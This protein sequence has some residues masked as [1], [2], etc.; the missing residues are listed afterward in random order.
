[1]PKYIKVRVKGAR[2]GVRAGFLQGSPAFLLLA[3]IK[4]NSQQRQ[5]ISTVDSEPLAL[6]IIIP[7]RIE[8][9]H[10]VASVYVLGYK[11]NPNNEL[12]SA[13]RMQH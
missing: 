4:V 8:L 6:P 10:N 9:Q 11:T 7:V 3:F 5:S 12:L 1:M 13:N 2:M